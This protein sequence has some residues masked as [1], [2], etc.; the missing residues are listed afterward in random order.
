M[1]ET[2][3][4]IAVEADSYPSKN[5]RPIVILAG[6]ATTTLVLTV[7][8]LFPAT[9]IRGYYADYVFPVGAL[10]V[11]LIA[12][13]GYG[14]ASWL[15]GVKITKSLL[16]TVLLL[17]VLAYFGAQYIEYYNLAP[18]YD[19]GTPV[20]FLT[21]F[22]VTTR[23]IAWLDKQ[24]NPGE[25]LGALGYLLRLGELSGF[26]LGSMGA[27]IFMKA[28]PYC[29]ACQVYMKNSQI[30]LL[31]ASVPLQKT[32]KMAA[33]EVEAYE[34]AQ[35]EAMEKAK[36]TV[37]LLVEAANAGD[38]PVFEAI[39]R[40][41][42]AGKKKFNRLPA[43]VVIKLERCRICYASTLRVFLYRGQGKQTDCQDLGRHDLPPTFVRELLSGRA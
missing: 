14:I 4:P 16:W 32:K 7:F 21:H 39:L 9:D 31:P 37:A 15:T 10:Y 18:T 33:E 34:A 1:V 11:G 12:S 2:P 20:G 3:A 28:K 42:A 22:N 13:S 40:E 27:P 43:R 19:D 23:G 38:C 25:P 30:V 41:H 29:E 6:A 35:H 17:Q 26:C 8:Y 24:G 36:A 5:L